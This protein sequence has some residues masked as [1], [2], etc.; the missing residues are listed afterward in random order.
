MEKKFLNLKDIDCYVVAYSLSNYIWEI[1]TKWDYFTKNSIG[2]QFARAMDS[3]SANIAEG[4]DRYNKQDT[5]KFYRYSIGS[6]Y[7]CLD[8]NQKSMKRKLIIQDEYNF[9]FENLGLMDI[10]GV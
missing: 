4:F 5:T 8:W 2:S 7:E 6:L 3:I 1:V 9:I 10:L